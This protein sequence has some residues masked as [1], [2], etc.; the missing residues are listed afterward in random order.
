[1]GQEH[2]SAGQ[3]NAESAVMTRV[4]TLKIVACGALIGLVGCQYIAP[5]AGVV[6]FFVGK[7]ERIVRVEVEVPQAD[8]EPA[9]KVTPPATRK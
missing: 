8:E 4:K 3:N 7:R 6:S 2:L 5:I 9:A 1:M